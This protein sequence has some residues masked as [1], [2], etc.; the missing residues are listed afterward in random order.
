MVF[1]IVVVNFIGGYIPY[2]GAFLDGD[3]WAGQGPR[4]AHPSPTDSLP[5]RRTGRCH[6]HRG[7]TLFA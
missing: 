1:T 4:G 2:I 3:L 7:F 6:E 5:G